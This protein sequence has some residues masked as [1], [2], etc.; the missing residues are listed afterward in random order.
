MSTPQALLQKLSCGLISLVFEIGMI[1]V[2]F[3]FL[4]VDLFDTAGTLVG[5]AT[6]RTLVRRWQTTLAWTNTACWFSSIYRCSSK[7]LSNTTSYESVSGVAE[8]G[9]TDPSCCRGRT[10]LLALFFCTCEWFRR[11]QH[12]TL[13]ISNSNSDDVRPDWHWLAWSW[14]QHGRGNMST[15]AARRTLLLRVSH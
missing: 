11:T 15:Y 12:R 4:F 2:V 8:G 6:K 13:S 5:V 1:S 14:K 3:A 9:R 7:I 10:F